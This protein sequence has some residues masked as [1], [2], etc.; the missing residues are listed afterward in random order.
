[1]KLSG[2]HLGFVLGSSPSQLIPLSLFRRAIVTPA[3]ALETGAAN[4][5]NPPIR[6]R[7]STKISSDEGRRENEKWCG[8]RGLSRGILHTQPGVG[9]SLLTTAPLSSSSHLG[10]GFRQGN[11]AKH[12][13]GGGSVR[14]HDFP[15]PS[16]AESTASR[17]DAV[18][19]TSTSVSCIRS[20]GCRCRCFSSIILNLLQ[21]EIG[22]AWME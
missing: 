14:C 16:Q 22:G 6:R 17:S 15:F 5:R 1:L 9:R 19:I 18:Q 7:P 4:C 10:L 3:L 11:M 2:R 20:P 12:G 21:T 8:Y 13:D